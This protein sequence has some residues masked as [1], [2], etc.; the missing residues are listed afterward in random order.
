MQILL[1]CLGD[2]KR[3]R[4]K[5]T[6]NIEAEGN[7]WN[8]PTDKIQRQSQEV[9]SKNIMSCSLFSCSVSHGRWAAR[10]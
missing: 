3:E 8:Y 5:E 1:K 10:K 7:T 2:I 4:E 9:R 6:E